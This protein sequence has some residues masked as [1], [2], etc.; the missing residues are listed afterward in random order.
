MFFQ[1][2]LL[3]VTSKLALLVLVILVSSSVGLG[4]KGKLTRKLNMTLNPNCSLPECKG[5]TDNSINLVHVTAEGDSDVL[6]YVWSSVGAPSVLIACTSLNST[7]EIDWK[8][9][10]NESEV[11]GSIN[12]SEKPYYSLGL[13]LAKIWQFNDT[14]DVGKLD[15]GSNISFPLPLMEMQWE[16]I[17]RTMHCSNNHCS[18]VFHT[19][20]S[21][22]KYF[23]PNGSFS[24]EVTAHSH[25]GRSNILPHLDHTANSSQLNIVLNGMNSEFNGSRFALEFILI[26]SDTIT[27]KES[28]VEIESQKSIDDEYTPGIFE[29]DV[30]MTPASHFTGSGGYLQWKPVCYTKDERTIAHSTESYSYG[31]QKT[32]NS[33]PFSIT[34][35]FFNSSLP[36]NSLSAF[37]ISFG[38]SG[39][40]FYLKTN[41]TSWSMT[42]GYG[43][44]PSD[45]FSLMII[46]II[47]I[48]LGT[49]L[50]L[51][52]VWG[53]G[54]C[55]QKF[56]RKQDDL[57]LSSD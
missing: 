29:R 37:N 30:L 47:S 48:G 24:F 56:T 9:L 20:S 36:P 50:I 11:E 12:F 57:L 52:V 3:L 19:L 38:S 33:L 14:E 8:N 26:G 23:L 35:A 27:E 55:V 15:S 32:N 34:K 25:D 28:N 16:N 39:D 18:A 41:Y 31:I 44:P 7:L 5:E 49:P 40:G 45:Q 51:M 17:N 1:K 13:V 4:N 2:S 43:R 42:V 6:H 22:P 21:D 46:L 10:L 53:V 54:F